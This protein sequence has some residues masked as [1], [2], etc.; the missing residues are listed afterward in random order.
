V[1]LRDLRV[2]DDALANAHFELLA[3]SKQGEENKG[4]KML[5]EE[6]ER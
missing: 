5:K 1:I 2:L 6:K 4:P 3:P